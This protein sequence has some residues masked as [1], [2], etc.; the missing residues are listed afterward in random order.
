MLQKH[1]YALNND[2]K[3]PI[4]SG[5]G[6]IMNFLRVS[7]IW[8]SLFIALPASAISLQLPPSMEL[9]IV[10]GTPVNSILLRG[11]DSLELTQGQHQLV[12]TLSKKTYDSHD[13]LGSFRPLYLIVLFDTWN[14]RR[15][16]FQ[17]PTLTTRDEIDHFISLPV[18][19]LVDEHDAPMN[20]AFSRL[21][22]GSEGVMAALRY[23]DGE[24]GATLP[25][26]TE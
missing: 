3:K 15:L 8:V 13:R 19:A 20:A 18:L 24:Y 26:P 23:H 2:G 12:L 10:D 17:L 5:K 6:N 11:A 9:L 1:Y 4:M 14:A 21:P 7:I 25:V 22:V 16:R